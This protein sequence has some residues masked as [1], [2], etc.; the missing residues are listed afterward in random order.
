MTKAN[1]LDTM[2][3][4][5]DAADKPRLSAKVAVWWNGPPG[6]LWFAAL[7]AALLGARIARHFGGWPAWLFFVAGVVA[8]A[9]AMD[10]WSKPQG[11]VR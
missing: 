6:I 2:G 3:V 7:F 1:Y 4:Q 11:W 10:R 8:V 9:A 5:R